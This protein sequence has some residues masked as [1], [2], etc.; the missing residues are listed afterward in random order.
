ME[1]FRRLLQSVEK[2]KAFADCRFA[3]HRKKARWALYRA[4]RRSLFQEHLENF[5]QQFGQLIGYDRTDGAEKLAETCGNLKKILAASR[6][7]FGRSKENFLR[8]PKRNVRF[9]Q[10]RVFKREKLFGGPKRWSQFCSSSGQRIVD[11]EASGLVNDGL[12][13]SMR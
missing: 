6:Q 12:V 10:I 13:C 4:D 8:K 1:F 5:L 11:E 7:V 2:R 9:S 3:C